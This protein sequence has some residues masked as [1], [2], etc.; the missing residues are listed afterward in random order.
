MAP[1][2]WI[3]VLTET[4]WNK[5]SLKDPWLL[6]ILG[7]TCTQ[8]QQGERNVC[9]CKYVRN[10][11]MLL[12]CRQNQHQDQNSIKLHHE[13]W[14]QVCERRTGGKMST[15]PQPAFYYPTSP[16]S[17]K[18]WQLHFFTKPPPRWPKLWAQLSRDSQR[19]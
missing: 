3:E 6:L 14:E 12:T 9:V 17:F 10:K 4:S 11:N 5:S 1:Q 13:R 19:L 7:Y 8:K 16:S 2:W 18:T 15:L